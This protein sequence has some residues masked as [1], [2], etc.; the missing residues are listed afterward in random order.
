M[1]S[2]V[3][4]NPCEAA[5]E[6][7]DSQGLAPTEPLPR[8]LGCGMKGRWALFVHLHVR[9]AAY[10]AGVAAA[11]DVVAYLC[12]AQ[13]VDESAACDGG[14]VAAAI[15]GAEDMGVLVALHRDGRIAADGAE[16]GEITGGAYP[17]LAIGIGGK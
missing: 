1:K 13:N 8:G 9:R 5:F 7:S 4:A 15:E 2:R 17:I 6:K 16:D 11:V 3:G 10:H 14:H 12:V